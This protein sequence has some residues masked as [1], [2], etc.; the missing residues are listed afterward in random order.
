MINDYTT[1]IDVDFN[2][3]IP[4]EYNLI[5]TVGETNTS[6]NTASVSVQ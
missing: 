4:N 3:G 1:P 2:L 6:N 5:S